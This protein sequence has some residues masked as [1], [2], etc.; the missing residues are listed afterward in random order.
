M[1]VQTQQ[2]DAGYPVACSCVTLPCFMP[3]SCRPLSSQL[4]SSCTY[5]TFLLYPLSSTV[6]AIAR[7]TCVSFSISRG[8]LGVHGLLFIRHVDVDCCHASVHHILWCCY[9]ATCQLASSL[10]RE[11]RVFYGLSVMY[12]ILVSWYRVT[13]YPHPWSAPCICW[14]MSRPFTTSSYHVPHHDQLLLR[15]IDVVT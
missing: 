1:Y 11:T 14:S 3:S 7:V 13:M 8:L 12:H 9:W 5:M 15:L 10:T 4:S 2:Q 6:T